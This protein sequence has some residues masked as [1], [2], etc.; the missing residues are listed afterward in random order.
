M[1]TS[2]TA[3]SSA[4]WL[5]KLFR[6]PGPDVVI[7]ICPPM[8]IVLWPWIMRLARRAP[9]V[10]HVQDLQ[11]DAA[12]NLGMLGSRRIARLLSSVERAALSMATHI[13]TISD[14]MRTRIASKGFSLSDISLV[15]N[16]TS[17]TPDTDLER[18]KRFRDK[19]DIGPNQILALYSGNLGRKQ[20][21]STLLDTANL[22][23]ENRSIRFL[24]IGQGVDEV[25][26][27]ARAKELELKN[28]RFG[29]LVPEEELSTLLT[30][31]DIHMIIQ[32]EAATDLVMPSKLTNIL[33]VGRP[34]V[35]TAHRDSEIGKVLLERNAGTIVPP[36]D[37]VALAA[38]V[39]TISQNAAARVEM[40][41]NARAYAEANLNINVILA[42]LEVTLSQ[43]AAR[44]AR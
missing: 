37:P 11:F 7:C 28:V 20:G 38:A 34:S 43:F 30:A 24:I 25:R 32:Q 13:S 15:P 26:L 40:G 31:A 14:S 21:L 6:R 44:R 10:L 19:H 42:G 12:M 3:N 22:L 8:Q 18:V 23:R 1:E 4:W 35:A 16:W 2:F 9:V 39:A 36:G 29:D 17:T 5:R 33:A 27:K 41:K